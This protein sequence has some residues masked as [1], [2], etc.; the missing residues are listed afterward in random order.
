LSKSRTGDKK[1]ED[2]LTDL[3]STAVKL[4]TVK[5]SEFRRESQNPEAK[6]DEGEGRLLEIG[7]AFFGC[8]RPAVLQ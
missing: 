3:N 2:R 5:E 1:S 8:S 4:R 7:E 6:P